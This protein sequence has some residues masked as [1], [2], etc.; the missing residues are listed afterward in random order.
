MDDIKILNKLEKL[1]QIFSEFFPNERKNE[2]V[3]IKNLRNIFQ[4]WKINEIDKADIKKEIDEINNI[5]SE[6][7][8]KKLDNYRNSIFFVELY[9]SAKKNN[10]QKNEKDI[11]KEAETNFNE[12]KNL[13]EEESWILNISEPILNKCFHSIKNEN[14]NVLRE[15]LKKLM[16]IFSINDFNELKLEGLLKNINI[17]NKKEEICLI[18]ESCLYFID[19][20]KIQKTEF[21]DKIE[22]AKKELLLMNFNLNKI[23]NLMKIL[24]DNGLNISQT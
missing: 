1:I 8:F 22:R 18:A 14:D 7:E 5:L 23:E 3:K 12:L 17:Y 19:E 16:S 6:E 13:F 9:R 11:L 15:E 20:L 2:I 4:T 21:S 10:N 24:E